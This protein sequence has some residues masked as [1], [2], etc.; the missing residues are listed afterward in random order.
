MGCPPC[1]PPGIIMPP[2]IPVPYIMS[3]I[4][5][6]VL[7]LSAY[8]LIGRILDTLHSDP[9]ERPDFAMP[10]LLIIDDLGTEPMVNNVTVECLLSIICERQDKGLATLFATN[11]DTEKLIERYGE[12]IVSRL[13]SPRTVKIIPVETAN[14]RLVK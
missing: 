10:E 5:I 7:K 2:C 11:L 8:N 1:I 4:V 6:S 9:S 3:V 13:L 14:V 12:R